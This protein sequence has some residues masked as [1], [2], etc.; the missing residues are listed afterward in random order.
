MN[1][2]LRWQQMYGVNG[3]ANQAAQQQYYND[4][5]NHFGRNTH[6]T[7]VT[8]TGGSSLPPDSYVTIDDENTR[9]KEIKSKL[10]LLEDV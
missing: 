4:L 10:L 6:A 1:D 8:I 9:L 2:L 7:S 3:L 5:S